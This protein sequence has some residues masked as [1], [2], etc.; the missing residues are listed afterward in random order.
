MIIDSHM[1]DT[2]DSRSERIKR[3]AC[4]TNSIMSFLF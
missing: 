4:E 1:T 3:F 2:D